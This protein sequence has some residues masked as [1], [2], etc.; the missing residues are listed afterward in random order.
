MNNWSPKDPAENFYVTFDFTGSATV[1]GSAV[2]TVEV[3]SGTDP[4][5]GAVLIGAPVIVGPVVQHKVGVG[6]AGCR[7]RFRCEATEGTSVYALTTTM[8]LRYSD[9]DHGQVA[10]LDYTS[11]DEIRAAL[12]VSD[13][14]VDDGVLGLPLYG[15]HLGMEFNNITDEFALSEDITT[16]VETI[17]GVVPATRTK[18]QR[19]VLSSVSLFA[20]YA[21]ARHLGTTLPMMAPKSIS[22]GKAVVTRFSDSPYKSTLLS[23]ESQYEKARQGLAAAL[24]ALNSTTA[25]QVPLVFMGVSSPAVDPVTGS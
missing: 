6:V 4:T 5:P 23:V 16:T 20:T 18:A 7:Y 22:D 14:E 24:A 21:V 17:E 1:I 3:E 13:E 12:G 19:R 2:V 10:V 25:A 11:Y 15:N 9:A 8:P